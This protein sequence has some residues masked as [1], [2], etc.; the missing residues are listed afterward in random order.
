[1]TTSV[2]W[3]AMLP[4]HKHCMRIKVGRF[5]A[6]T[7]GVA[8]GNRNNCEKLNYNCALNNS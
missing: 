3:F 4:Y 8:D 2:K 7:S 5:V 6:S 1:M